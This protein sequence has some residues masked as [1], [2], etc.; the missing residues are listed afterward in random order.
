M[1]LSAF[2]INEESILDA[3]HNKR[4]PLIDKFDI[5]NK[6]SLSVHSF[7]L[8]MY[9]YVSC[10]F[11]DMELFLMSCKY[12]RNINYIEL[13]QVAMIYNQSNI[14]NY[15]LNLELL[16]DERWVILFEAKLRLIDL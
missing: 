9:Q 14:L 2:D 1:E 12:D 3:L 10:E 7:Y 4:D 5:C 8:K 15:I 6:S 11:G 16:P 13:A